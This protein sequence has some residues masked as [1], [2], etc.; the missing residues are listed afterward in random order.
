MLKVRKNKYGG[1]DEIFKTLLM[2]PDSQ[3][4]VDSTGTTI[5]WTVADVDDLGIW[6]QAAP[7][8]I[9]IPT[10]IRKLKIYTKAEWNINGVGYRSLRFKING[11]LADTPYHPATDVRVANDTISCHQHTQSPWTEITP[12]Q[13]GDIITFNVRQASGADL[14]LIGNRSTYLAVEMMF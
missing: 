12:T 8:D 5:N 3:P 11:A 2:I 1:V 7:S 9:V 10:G 4:I 14:Q 13:W 6:D